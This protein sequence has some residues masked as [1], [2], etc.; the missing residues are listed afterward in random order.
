VTEVLIAPG[1]VEAVNAGDRL[2]LHALADEYEAAGHPL[3]AG[4]RRIAADNREPSEWSPRGQPDRRVYSWLRYP[5]GFPESTMRLTLDIFDWLSSG[6]PA[7]FS[8]DGKAS[9]ARDYDSRLEAYLDL[10]QAL[11]D[12]QQ[13]ARL[14]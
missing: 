11:L 5:G 7:Y 9:Y 4:L 13:H 14:Q 8:D 3:A 6:R 2:A 12:P 1:I 10:A